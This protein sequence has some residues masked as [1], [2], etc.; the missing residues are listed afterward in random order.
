MY[1]KWSD[2]EVTLALEEF[3]ASKLTQ[4]EFCKRNGFVYST[5]NM[6]KKNRS[7]PSKKQSHFIKAVLPEKNQ[8]IQNDPTGYEVIVNNINEVKQLIKAV[9]C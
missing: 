1:Q 5:F 6:W 8:L 3:T 9:S 4:K 7:E 2:D